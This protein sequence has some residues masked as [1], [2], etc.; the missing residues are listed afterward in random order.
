MS[1]LAASSRAR[2]PSTLPS[3][4]CSPSTPARNGRGVELSRL[5]PGSGE[6]AL[7]GRAGEAD[8]FEAADRIADRDA[9][10]PGRVVFNLLHRGHV[11]VEVGLAA[12]DMRVNRAG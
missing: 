6:V 12:E 4:V 8:Q 3:T 2:L 1:A 9:V 11:V 5:R 7:V 10:G